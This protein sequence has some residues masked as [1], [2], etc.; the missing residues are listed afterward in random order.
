MQNQS[1]QKISSEQMKKV[2]ENAVEA[3]QILY[4]TVKSRKEREF[5]ENI[6]NEKYK[7]V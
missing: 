2:T 6:K 1:I 7:R 5:I 4:A 3:M